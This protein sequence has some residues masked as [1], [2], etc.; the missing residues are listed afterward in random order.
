VIAAARRA[1]NLIAEIANV[2]VVE[3]TRG[4]RRR[5]R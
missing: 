3:G 2:V 1:F 5:V 4:S